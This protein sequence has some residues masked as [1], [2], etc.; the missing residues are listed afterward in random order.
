MDFLLQGTEGFGIEEFGEP[1]YK[2]ICFKR[3]AQLADA[4]ELLTEAQKEAEE[5][6]MTEGDNPPIQLLDK[7]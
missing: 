5:A 2:L 7:E 3:M 1:A 6:Y 4:I